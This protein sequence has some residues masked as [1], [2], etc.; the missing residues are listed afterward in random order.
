MPHFRTA[1]TRALAFALS[2]GFLVLAACDTGDPTSPLEAPVG[3]SAAIGKTDVCHRDEDG[4]F[5][6]IS[7]AGFV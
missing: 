5:R 4:I 6:K 1:S 3:L 2:A 7:V